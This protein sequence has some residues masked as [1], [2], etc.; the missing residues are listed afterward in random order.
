MPVSAEI[1]DDDINK[2]LSSLSRKT[3]NLKPVFDLFGPYM[4]GQLR[5]YIEAERGP[6]GKPWAP[7]SPSWKRQKQREVRDRGIGRYTLSMFTGLDYV[8]SETELAV[9]S[10][11]VYAPSFHFGEP[12]RNQP[13]RPLFGIKQTD[14]DR[15]SELIGNYLSE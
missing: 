6:D 8:A 2:R 15:L 10:D 9:G 5:G 12:R 1:T 13:A 3:S 7:L 14:R 11:E 4:L